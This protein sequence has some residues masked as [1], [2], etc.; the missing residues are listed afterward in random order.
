MVIWMPSCVA[1][2]FGAPLGRCELSLTWSVGIGWPD[3]SLLVK[4]FS[5]ENGFLISSEKAETVGVSLLTRWISD[6][7]QYGFSWQNSTTASSMTLAQ[8]SRGTPN[9]PEL[10]AG[11]AIDF[12]LAASIKQFLMARLRTRSCL[13][14]V[15]F[16]RSLSAV[17]SHL[18]PN[19]WMIL[20]HSNLSATV[21]SVRPSKRMP[22]SAT[23]W[24]QWRWMSLPPS[25]TMSLAKPPTCCKFSW[26]ALTIAS[27]GCFVTSFLK[28]EISF[29]LSRGSYKWTR[30]VILEILSSPFR[31]W[32]ARIRFRFF[33]L[34]WWYNY[35][36][37]Q[38]ILAT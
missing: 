17:K 32:S 23:N 31:L 28:T 2:E 6:K 7:W 14:L 27:T 15:P 3:T 30:G 37:P 11:I 26:A 38:L 20:L 36:R 29:F 34:E 25:F 35:L 12:R 16:L 13:V 4:L 1:K 21:T 18:G 10:T 19:M 9:T 5:L 24:S 22:F 8:R 33:L